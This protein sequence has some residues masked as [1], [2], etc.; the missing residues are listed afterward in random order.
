[1]RPNGEGRVRSSSLP[2]LYPLHVLPFS[3][4]KR[5]EEPVACTIRRP[6]RIAPLCVRGSRAFPSQCACK[7]SS[8]LVKIRNLIQEVWDGSWPF[9]FLT[10]FQVMLMLLIQGSHFENQGLFLGN[11]NEW[12]SGSWFC[13][14]AVCDPCSLPRCEQASGVREH[15]EL[16]GQ[17]KEL[18]DSHCILCMVWQMLFWVC[19]L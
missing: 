15:R 17:A 11:K 19:Y 5:A 16:L 7:S 12:F 13:A 2:H 9:A 14:W 8:H 3:R 1:M 4:N 10:S 6:K 18:F